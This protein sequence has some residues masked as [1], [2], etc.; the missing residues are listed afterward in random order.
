[1][2]LKLHTASATSFYKEPN[3]LRYLQNTANSSQKN[4]SYSRYE[5]KHEKPTFFPPTPKILTLEDTTGIESFHFDLLDDSQEVSSYRN[6]VDEKSPKSEILVKLL[7][8]NPASPN[9]QAQKQAYLTIEEPSV[10]YD[11]KISPKNGV[12]TPTIIKEIDHERSSSQ[13]S[14]IIQLTDANQVDIAVFEHMKPGTANLFGTTLVPSRFAL[15]V[16]SKNALRGH[17]NE[18]RSGDIK[19]RV[20]SADEANQTIVSPGIVS[21][22]ASHTSQ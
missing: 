22:A 7:I 3:S 4:F 5:N 10:E 18:V 12:S 11:T 6:I 15:D 13:G 20:L 9:L 2:S 19:S 1:M 21:P 14:E 8:A 17:S 16:M